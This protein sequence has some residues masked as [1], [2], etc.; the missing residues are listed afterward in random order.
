MPTGLKINNLS[1]AKMGN[2]NI[3]AVKPQSEDNNNGV[4]NVQGAIVVG[5]NKI[6][7]Q[8]G[9]N[10]SQNANLKVVPFIN[11]FQNLQASFSK[12]APIK[13]SNLKSNNLTI[14][15]ISAKIFE[16]IKLKGISNQ[17]PEIISLT[18]FSS[19]YKGNSN[20]ISDVGNFINTSMASR[21]LRI[22][23]I[24]ALIESIQENEGA[25]KILEEIL[26]K[27]VDEIDEANHTVRVMTKIAKTI[28]NIKKSLDIRKSDN[29]SDDKISKNVVSAKS[30]KDFLVDLYGFSE[31][32]VDNFS[33]TKLIGQ[34]LIDSRTTLSQYSPSLFGTSSPL[35]INAINVGKG[36]LANK[37]KINDKLFNV[38]FGLSEADSVE[39]GIDRDFGSYNAN[40]IDINDGKFN[41]QISSYKNKSTPILGTEFNKF[42]DSLPENA[43]DRAA[44]LIMTLS[45]EMRISSG[46]GTETIKSI[47]VNKLGGNDVGDPFEIIFGSPGDDISDVPNGTNSLCSLL[48]YKN[49]SNNVILPF[50]SLYVRGENGILYI[51]GS[52]ELGDSI[53]QS[54]IPFDINK[55]RLFQER[56][57]D[58]SSDSMS[59]IKTLLGTEKLKSPLKPIDFFNTISWNYVE[60][61]DYILGNIPTEVQVLPSV[62]G[63]VSLLKLALSDRDIKG[64]LFEYVLALGLIGKPGIGEFGNN[65]VESFFRDMSL[66]EI[67]KW[68][69]L[70]SIKQDKSLNQN[71]ITNLNDALAF[72]NASPEDI[73]NQNNDDLSKSLTTDSITGY[74]VLALLVQ[75]IINKM[76][77]KGDINFSGKPVILNMLFT[78]LISTKNL[79]FLNRIVDFISNIA[80]TSQNF[81]EN[82]KT[83]FNRLSY[84]TIAAISFEAFFAYLEP[85]LDGISSPNANDELVTF[86]ID[87]D[88]L[89][90][91]KNIVETI[92]SNFNLAS[93]PSN[94]KQVSQFKSL[95]QGNALNSPINNLGSKLR[96]EEEIVNQIILRLKRTFNLVENATSDAVDYFRTD[97]KNYESLKKLVE[98][99]GGKERIALIDEAQFI[100]SRKAQSDF[101]DGDGI[102]LATKG[103]LT[104]RGGADSKKRA[105]NTTI[106]RTRMKKIQSPIF[107]DGSIISSN[108]KKLMEII[109]NNP[110][111]KGSRSENLKILTVGIPAGFSNSFSSEVSITEENA[112]KILN[113]QS[114]VISINVYKRSIE[115]EDIVFKPQ[116]FIFEL[117]R[118]VTRPKINKN[119]IV[120]TNYVEFLNNQSI[121]LTRDFSAFGEDENQNKEDFFENKEYS[122]LTK[123]QKENLA[124]NHVE[125]FIL[126]M[127]LRLL[128]GISTDENDFLVNDELFE[129]MIDPD[130]KSKFNDLILTYVKGVTQQPITL[131][132]LKQSSP[133]IS[134]LLGK[135]ETLSLNTS[136]AEQVNPPILPGVSISKR[137]E[138]TEDII[139]FVKLY[140]PKSLLTGGKTHALRITSP[141]IFERIYNIAVDPDDFEIDFDKTLETVSGKAMYVVLEKKGMLIKSKDGKIK[142][143]E[144]NKNNTISLDQFFINIS[145]M[146]SVEE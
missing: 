96:K 83:R 89:K 22:E 114:D 18:D 116:S 140:S 67:K 57:S 58:I 62:W 90:N 97:S 86:T 126:G 81:V 73:E 4:V 124:I 118:F 41:F 50:E 53:L 8:N 9:G 84:T 127:Y 11:E 32:G 16:P 82:G 95:K 79:V 94:S 30:Y 93:K 132:Q 136:F 54:E 105:D 142:I 102:N 44:L 131:E 63:E 14:S 45:K 119:K 107:I 122:F 15:P 111:F 71:T 27:Y 48:R 144:R 113:K 64:L 74:T 33:N 68:G 17:R 36:F 29:F 101:Y 75:T 25:N 110:K 98:E 103:T 145:T 128:I 43:M 2:I 138:L 39:R 10:I 7:G 112:N 87:I 6:V 66:E 104:F 35:S 123:S 121:S 20:S 70:P 91:S 100:L 13:I 120:S 56:L 26:N 129:G 1:F 99:Q 37:P 19:I 109:L 38:N 51:P 143:K 78:H 61:I 34:F 88:S 23:H 146:Q 24:E 137:I 117:S 40:K 134:A 125:S 31:S 130:S 52:K 60:A 80:K 77:L 76:K 21:I 59:L 42:I 46:L 49:D 108:E 115:F 135:I 55:V 12:L 28:D 133:Q 106:K 72:L 47:L 3:Q 92:L 69:D 139:N 85:L 141:K 65:N 5:A